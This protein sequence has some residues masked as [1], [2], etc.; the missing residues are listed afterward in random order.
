MKV[1]PKLKGHILLTGGSGTL[2]HA[3]VELA[4]QL[5]LDCQFTVFSRDPM[6]QSAMRHK[7]PDLQFVI[8]DVRDKDEVIKAMAGHDMVI[9]AAAMK[10]IPEAEY[11][12]IACYAVNVTGS[13]NVLDA[14]LTLGIEDVVLITTDKACHPSNSYGCTKMMMERLAFSYINADM[15]IYLPRYG[16]VITSTGSVARIWREQLVKGEPISV[17]DPKMTRFWLSPQRAAEIVVESLYYPNRVYV[18]KLPALSLEKMIVYAL[19]E[20][21][22]MEVIGLRPGE[23]THEEL[24]T[25]E[26]SAYAADMDGA[27]I[28]RAPTLLRADPFGNYSSQK[29]VKEVE[30]YEMRKMLGLETE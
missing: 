4:K 14:A 9:H 3:I 11:D 19:E 10:H 7:Y 26:E 16:N 30:R 17:T 1:E 28:V 2:G 12:P 25:F 18:P 20:G 23:K 21:V 27:Y 29:P 13:Q 22:P 15:N 24:L 8:G 6:K 5:D